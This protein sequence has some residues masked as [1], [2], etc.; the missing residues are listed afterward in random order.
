MSDSPIGTEA[1]A[2]RRRAFNLAAATAIAAIVATLAVTATANWNPSYVTLASVAGLVIVVALAIAAMTQ[3]HASLRAASELEKQNAS[4]IAA[5]EEVATA[6]LARARFIAD[7]SHDLRQPLHALGLFLDALE[8]RVTPG[9][10]EKILAR[11]REASSVMNRAFGALIDLT[12]VEA[13]TLIPEV[14][15][16]AVDDLLA[17]LEEET[18]SVVASAGIDLRVVRSQ[19]HVIADQRLVGHMLRTLLSNAVEN[20]PGRLLLG[21]HH[22]SNRLW[23]EL[24]CSEP[25]KSTAKWDV[26]AAGAAR[27]SVR[28]IEELDLLVVRRLADLMGLGVRVTTKEDQGVAIAIGVPRA[29]DN[30]A[31]PL[32]DRA[33]LLIADDPSRRMKAAALLA[34]A[35]AV[36]HVA[37]NL[38]QADHAAR[39]NQRLDLLVTDIADGD[40]AVRVTRARIAASLPSLPNR[41]PA[42]KLVAAAQL[43][44][45]I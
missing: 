17:R 24:H 33:I 41:T 22:D 18:A 14:E 35:G 10:G 34:G 42:D 25:G 9:E 43:A 7:V 37:C 27:A 40:L 5:S 30:V 28:S 6:N 1:A 45:K 38:R 26:L 8:R 32:H 19:A 23:L 3:Q 44:L 2:A 39:T 20:G 15:V 31:S 36:V 29:G 13:D 11:T 16:F 12:K 4:L 21:A